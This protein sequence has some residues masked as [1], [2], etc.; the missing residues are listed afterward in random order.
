MQLRSFLFCFFCT[1]LGLSLSE[2]IEN[3]SA[4][5]QCGLTG[6]T[7]TWTG[8]AVDSERAIVDERRIR[9]EN[10]L[11]QDR[12]NYTCSCDERTENH[13]LNVISKCTY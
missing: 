12:G 5:I 13:Y 10:A 3:N 4:S 11:L 6:C 9:I 7:V 2:V 8:P 1:N